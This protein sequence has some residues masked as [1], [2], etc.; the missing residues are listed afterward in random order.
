MNKT[1]LDLAFAEPDEARDLIGSIIFDP[2]GVPRDENPIEVAKILYWFEKVENQK[3]LMPHRLAFYYDKLEPLVRYTINLLGYGNFEDFV[4]CLIHLKR[5]SKDPNYDIFAHYS[6]IPNPPKIRE[7]HCKMLV[8]ERNTAFIAYT[9]R[10]I[11][12][13]PPYIIEH[14]RPKPKGNFLNAMGFLPI[15]LL[16]DLR[17]NGMKFYHEDWKVDLYNRF[18]VYRVLTNLAE[19]HDLATNLKK[20]SEKIERVKETLATMKRRLETSK[21]KQKS[22]TRR[23][24]KINHQLKAAIKFE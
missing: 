15:N 18:N 2:L 11:I 1:Y 7:Y 12:G 16:D 14:L 20:V 10:S 13:C 6:L 5:K 24:R 9:I 17:A 23:A 22:T 21:N 8:L 19:A 3:E 4:L